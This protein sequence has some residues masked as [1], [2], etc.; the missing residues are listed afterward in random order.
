MNYLGFFC[1]RHILLSVFKVS[2]D[3]CSSNDIGA[4]FRADT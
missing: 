1:K 2:L 3:M 4:E